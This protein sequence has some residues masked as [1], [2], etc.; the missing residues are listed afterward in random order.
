[1]PVLMIGMQLWLTVCWF[2]TSVVS[3][4]SWPGGEL[5]LAL[6]W[7]KFSYC[8]YYLLTVVHITLLIQEFFVNTSRNL[9]QCKS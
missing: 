4:P 6:L 9:L 8:F 3:W 1:M 2:I 5:V 7:V